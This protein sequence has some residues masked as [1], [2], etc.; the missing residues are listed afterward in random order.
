MVEDA[1]IKT[2]RVSNAKII[3]IVADMEVHA[4]EGS[5]FL[6]LLFVCENVR[7]GGG[8]NRGYG[9]RS[10]YDE[11]RFDDRGGRDNGYNNGGGY[12]GYQGGGRGGG[13][14][15]YGGRYS[16]DRRSYNNGGQ[17][18]RD[19]QPQAPQ[20]NS[21]WNALREDTPRKENWDRQQPRDERLES[22]LFAGQLSGINF[23]K[24]E[25]IPVEA[26]GDDVPQPI[27]LV[28]PVFYIGNLFFSV[29]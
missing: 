20:Q 9:G 1:K 21:R 8:Q 28:C 19:D 7:Y 22:E 15:G 16:D 25:E 11:R 26:T 13:G 23:D 6:G 12:G 5:F 18:Q 10:S 4:V 29:C 14:G 27:S 3:R 24:Y 17:Q 2:R